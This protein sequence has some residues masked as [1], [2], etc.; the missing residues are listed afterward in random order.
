M[1]NNESIGNSTSEAGGTPI[2][3]S[4][5]ANHATSGEGVDWFERP[6]DEIAE[7]KWDETS[8]KSVEDKAMGA[9]QQFCQQFGAEFPQEFEAMVRDCWHTRNGN[10]EIEMHTGHIDNQG[11]HFDRFEFKCPLSGFKGLPVLV[12]ISGKQRIQIVS[13]KLSLLLSDQ[14]FEA[15]GGSWYIER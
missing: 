3:T 10:K 2:Y 5:D 11:G 12:A 1:T 9:L 13:L 4:P 14:I 6:S 7:R 15:T 8:D